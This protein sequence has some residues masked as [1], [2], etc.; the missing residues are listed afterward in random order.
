MELGNEDYLNMEVQAYLQIK[1]SIGKK[2]N[3]GSFFKAS[4]TL[5]AKPLEL[6]FPFKSIL[7]GGIGSDRDRQLKAS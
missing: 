6:Y 4:V 1:E 2:L 5:F 3:I 7:S